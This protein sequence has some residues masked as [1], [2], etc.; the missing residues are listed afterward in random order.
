MRAIHASSLLAVAGLCAAAAGQPSYRYSVSEIVPLPG[1]SFVYPN[2]INTHGTVVGWSFD[3]PG[4]ES[5]W[6][7]TAATG[8]RALPKPPG[9]EWSRPTD[10]NEE[11]VIVGYAL[12]VWSA[13]QSMVA[14]KY[15]ND[16]FTLYP[17]IGTAQNI[18]NV[19]AFVGRSCLSGLN[20]TCY[21][22]AQP[23]QVPQSFAP[24]NTYSSSL[25]RF[26]DIND[27]GQIAYV[28]PSGPGIRREPDGTLT[29]MPLPPAPYG[30]S[31]W[32][33]NNAGQIAGQYGYSV[34]SQSFARAYIWNQASGFTEIGIPNLHVRARGLN[35]LGH[36]VG[37]TGSNENSSLGT[38][39]WTP[40]RGSEDLDPLID[41]ALQIVTTSVYG[42][43]DAG[44]IMGSGTRLTP[45]VA[46][47]YY[48]L[49]P[50][51][52]PCYP[53]CDG[54]TSPPVLNVNDF[55]CF[56]ARFA[57]ADP[58]ADCDRSTTL[59]VNDFVC[60]QGRFAA[61]CP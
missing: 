36:V 52:A 15:E 16:Q 6:I 7:W 60:F 32:A 12:P 58:Y 38:W 53:N 3:W 29:Q 42:I 11:G 28:D 54:S 46:G 41:P 61:G 45:P 22:K 2:A 44:Q 56:Q 25:W 26:I 18:N 8:T 47:I 13:E 4:V 9:F 39:I 40:E 23:G 48:V 5:P 57:A 50:V 1:H 20:L 24:A 37:E 35:N 21:T 43:N 59:N 49:T 51:A 10:I 33:I 27:P 31:I 34:G 14:W 17:G 55:V 30:T 19:G